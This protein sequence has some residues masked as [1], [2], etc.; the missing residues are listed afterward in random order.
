LVCPCPFFNT[1]VGKVAEDAKLKYGSGVSRFSHESED[2][3][4]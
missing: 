3:R 1:S 4:T 2:P